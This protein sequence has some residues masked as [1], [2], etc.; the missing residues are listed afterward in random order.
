MGC[1]A[2]G[3]LRLG[4]ATLIIAHTFFNVTRAQNDTATTNDAPMATSS[5]SNDTANPFDDT[6]S[7]ARIC[8]CQL[9]NSTSYSAFVYQEY[10]PPECCCG[11]PGTDCPDLCRTSSSF[12]SVCGS[13]QVCGVLLLMAA[14]IG[15]LAVTICITGVFLARRRRQRAHLQQFFLAG[16][17]AGGAGI[18]S[19]QRINVV[20]I[21]DEQL[22]DLEIKDKELED[23]SLPTPT[24]HHGSSV[25]EEQGRGAMLQTECPICLEPIEHRIVSEFPCGHTCCRGCRD[26]L[27]YHSSRVVNASTVAILCPLCRKLAV[28]PSPAGGVARRESSQQQI[29]VIRPVR[30]EQDSVEGGV[31][32]DDPAAGQRAD[33]AD[34]ETRVTRT[35]ATAVT[36]ALTVPSRGP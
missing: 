9:S 15:T 20:Q 18:G 30:Q 32:R 36:T 2:C 27:V 31:N 3:P 25:D 21:P 23:V 22:K 13:G 4:A 6:T 14:L 12:S 29:I 28:A 34:E 24:S 16:G 1:G 33:V 35:S 7:D 11:V 10:A 19:V 5:P 8:C 26:D 17:Q